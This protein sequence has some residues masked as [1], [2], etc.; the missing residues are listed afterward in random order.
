MM[1]ID[2][3]ARQLVAQSQEAIMQSPSMANAALFRSMESRE[4]RLLGSVWAQSAVCVQTNRRLITE[5]RYHIAASRRRL[6]SAFA[7]AGAAVSEH[8]DLRASIRAR[9]ARGALFPVSG[10]V[11][12]GNGSGKPC[13]VCHAAINH[14]DVEYEIPLGH[15][16]AVVSHLRCYVPWS[17]E[18]LTMVC[19]RKMLRESA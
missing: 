6:N 5:S 12:A 16:V 7:L 14:M 10:Y 4:D 17:E 3:K 13:V 11:T 9:L 15:H 18:S 2:L 19:E 1:G 8:Q